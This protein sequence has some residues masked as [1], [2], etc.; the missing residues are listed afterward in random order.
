MRAER[1]L[2][3]SDAFKRFLAVFGGIRALVYHP[4]GMED[5]CYYLTAPYAAP[6]ALGILVG[7]D[8]TKISRLR[9]WG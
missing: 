3:N 2:R 7:L 1:M 4:E 6:T 8:A 5:K 9:R